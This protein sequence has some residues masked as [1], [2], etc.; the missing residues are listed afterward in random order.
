MKEIKTYLRQQ[1]DVL[2][3]A[4]FNELGKEEGVN[5][6]KTQELNN[7]IVAFHRALLVL[8][9]TEKIVKDGI[10]EAKEK[11]KN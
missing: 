2:Q 3:N 10:K 7:D 11:T 5:L 6:V 8:D 1:I 9:K 4:L